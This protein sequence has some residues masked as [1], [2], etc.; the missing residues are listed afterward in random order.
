MR[1][2]PTM[3]LGVLL[4]GSANAQMVRTWTS[5]WDRNWS[6]NAN[7]SG[8]NR[9]N[10]GNEIAQFGTGGQLDPE[11]NSDSYTVRGLRFSATAAGYGVHDDNGARTLRIGNGSSG[12][13][14]NLSGSDQVISI[15]T[16][17]FQAGATI[18]TT[19]SGGLAVASD[20]TGLNR[21]LTISAVGDIALS[22]RIDTGSG[23]LTK[24]GAGNLVLGGANTYTGT[25]SID[26]GAIVLAASNVFNDAGRINVAAGGS[27][28]LN[29]QAD[30]IGGLDGT[31]IV[32]FGATGTGRLVLT[33]GISTFA[34]A[35]AGRGEVVVGA[36]AT[37]RLAAD[38]SNTGLNIRLDG[39]T[40]E[41]AGHALT[42]GSFDVSASS[43]VDFDAST[44]S[45]LDANA[46]AVDAAGITLTVQNWTDA[47]D[48][49]YSHTAYAPQ[50]PPLSQVGFAGWTTADTKWQAYDSQITP[51]PEPASYGALLLAGTIAA[52]CWRR[53]DRG[54]AVI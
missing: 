42:I 4:I 27:L 23:Q 26:A 22:G 50:T 8:N 44:D 47:A 24:Q 43:T 12:F 21:D 54:R 32:D 30:A 5:N 20:L 39:G 16:L 33:Q 17:Q 14:E 46:V 35:F 19:G 34:G 53:R 37:L 29:D 49:F 1:T 48:Y 25:T 45:V 52:A 7:W 31:G 38:F 3:L 9:P 41:L 13:I 11:L 28:R 40:L 18:R 51:V 15:A 10:T 2:L 6:R 36:G